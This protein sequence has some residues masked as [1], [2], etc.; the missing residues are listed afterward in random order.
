MAAVTLCIDF[1]AQENLFS[2]YEIDSIYG[3][4]N[5]WNAS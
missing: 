2:S 1:G 3:A 4:I 5:T